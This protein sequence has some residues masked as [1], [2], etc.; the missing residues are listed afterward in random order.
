MP[1]VLD[2]IYARQAV[3]HCLRITFGFGLLC[4]A[5]KIVLS[6][7]IVPEPSPSCLAPLGL[8][9]QA[10]LSQVT[11]TLKLLQTCLH[12]HLHNFLPLVSRLQLLR[13]KQ[14]LRRSYNS[15]LTM[16]SN[17]QHS[18][19]LFLTHKTLRAKFAVPL[20]RSCRVCH[21]WMPSSLP[22]PKFTLT[23]L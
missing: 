18:M 10:Q 21:V 15:C 9:I 6:A 23:T 22:I 2:K 7:L 19:V 17:C 5:A 12:K 4:P 20:L 11:W 8:E 16:L 14:P 13:P 3:V 1:I